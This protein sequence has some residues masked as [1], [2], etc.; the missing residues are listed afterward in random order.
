MVFHL[1]AIRLKLGA[2][3]LAELA[4]SLLRNVSVDT[5]YFLAVLA[6]AGPFAKAAASAPD[7]ELIRFQ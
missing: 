4:D 5:L 3:A 6:D 2:D 1:V 7:A